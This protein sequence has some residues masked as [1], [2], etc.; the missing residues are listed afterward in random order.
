MTI[1]ELIGAGFRLVAT[2]QHAGWLNLVPDDPLP[3]VLLPESGIGVQLRG[4]VPITQA[5]IRGR[6]LRVH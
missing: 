3:R 2:W 4:A 1:E 6:F 5:L